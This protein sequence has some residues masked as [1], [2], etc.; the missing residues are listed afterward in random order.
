MSYL[1]E[2]LVTFKSGILN[3][4]AQTIENALK[5]GL[6]YEVDDFNKGKYFSYVSRQKTDT[7]ARKEAEELSDKLLANIIIENYKIIS[8]RDVPAKDA[9][10]KDFVTKDIAAKDSPDNIA[11][12][13]K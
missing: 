11:D 10:A 7:A 1:V 4:E 9:G 3:A 8:V 6:G 5:E 12:S 13:V 2:I